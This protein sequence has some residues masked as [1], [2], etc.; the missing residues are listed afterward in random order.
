[1]F[2]FVFQTKTDSF[3]VN[4]TK[5]ASDRNTNTYTYIRREE[6]EER[7]EKRE[8][9]REKRGERE[10]EGV[11]ERETGERENGEKKGKRRERDTAK[12]GTC[13]RPE[14]CLRHHPPTRQKKGNTRQLLIKYV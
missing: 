2:L 5:T 13:A 8:E 4:K 10:K 14:T 1:M 9:R 6:R 3:I 12:T 11:R 7:R